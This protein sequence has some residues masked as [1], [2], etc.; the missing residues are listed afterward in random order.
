MVSG[1]AMPAR[2]VPL[3]VASAARSAP[4]QTRRRRAQREKTE[5]IL[6][7]ALEVFSRRGLEG[8]RLD[9]IAAACNV[10]K[11]NLLYYYPTKAA[12]YRA[13]LEWLLDKWLAPLREID[14][15][16]DP[17]AALTGYIVRK[18]AYARSHPAASRLFCQEMLQGAPLLGEV[19]SGDLARL[20]DEKT[21]VIEGWV[22]RGLLAPIDPRHLIFAI[23]ATTQHYADFAVQ[24]AAVTRQEIDDDAL[25]EEARRTLLRIFAGLMRPRG[26]ADPPA[27][28]GT[29]VAFPWQD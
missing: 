18:L 16:R 27:G 19:L 4:A 24:I 21:A 23:W 22:R 11:T 14:A 29:Q 9:E 20:V 7:G 2:S 12:L 13:A 17:D 28:C 6:A 26:Q 5:R 8:A 10:S 3:D 25:W 1:S 15:T